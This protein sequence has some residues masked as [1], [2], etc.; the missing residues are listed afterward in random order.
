MEKSARAI[1]PW[2]PRF[3]S[4]NL[5]NSLILRIIQEHQKGHW[6]ARSQRLHWIHSKFLPPKMSCAEFNTS[7][8]DW[9]AF[10]ESASIDP[11]YSPTKEAFPRRIEISSSRKN[12]GHRTTN[13]STKFIALNRQEVIPWHLVSVELL[14]NPLPYPISRGLRWCGQ[15]IANY[16]S[17]NFFR[18]NTAHLS[19]GWIRRKWSRLTCT[20]I[21]RDSPRWRNRRFQL[22]KEFI[23]IDASI[24][25]WR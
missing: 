14:V 1:H 24:Y 13:T 12:S 9:K 11:C 4:Q 20:I 3:E 23:I 25:F 19:C 17:K 7:M 18:W 10:N 6:R 8:S 5:L 22:L 16:A 21:T 2:R 15:K